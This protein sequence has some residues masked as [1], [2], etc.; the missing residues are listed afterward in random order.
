MRGK[1]AMGSLF[2]GTSGYSYKHWR[3]IFYH[4]GLPQTRWLE[5]Y[6]QHFDTV[7]LNV[8]FYRLPAR[9]TFVGWYNKT[10]PNFVFAAKG[11]RFITHIKRLKDCQQPL[12]AYKENA[13][14]LGEKLACILWQLPPNLRYSSERLVEFCRLLR[15]EYCEK[16]HVFEFRHESWLQEDCYD[17]LASHSFALCIPLS[18]DYPRAEQMTAPFSYIRF[19]SGEV[20]GN[21]CYTDKELK[22]WASKIRAWLEER[23]IYIYF[24]NDAFGY[25]INNAKKLRDYINNL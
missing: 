15:A 10:P 9:K 1:S 13:A 14:G 18:P 19:H 3:G 21:S 5:F 20:L 16:R 4:V 17:I 24:N 11:S 7:E 25:A 6:C 22:Q 2:L 23:D 8:T 12:R